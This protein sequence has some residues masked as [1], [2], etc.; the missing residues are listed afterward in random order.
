M[1]PTSTSLHR[2]EAEALFFERNRHMAAGDSTATE[3]CFREA[4]L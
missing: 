2:S 4:R 1:E 3:A